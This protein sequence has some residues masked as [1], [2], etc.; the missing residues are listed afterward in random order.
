MER[1]SRPVGANLVFALRR[2]LKTRRKGEHEVRPYGAFIA[3]VLTAVSIA[4]GEDWPAWRGPAGSGVARD[5]RLPLHWGPK[6]NLRWRTPLPD[7]GNSTPIVCG[8]RVLLTQA[9]EKDNR[10]TVMC[11]DRRDGRVLWTSG[12]AAD[13]REPS[14]AQNPSCS[15]SPVTD[16]RVVVAYFGSPGLF[17]YDVSDGREL[18][19]RELGR[20]DS[21]QG[22]GSSPVIWRDLCVV[23]AGPGTDAAVVA[24]ELK[25]GREVW[26]IQSPRAEGGGARPADQPPPPESN[27]APDAP[28]GKFDDAMMAA[29]P[30]GAGGYLGSWST[31]VLIRNGDREE[32]VVVHPLQVS[33]YDPATGRELWTCREM[34]EQAFASPAVAGD[35]LVALGRPHDGGGTRATAIKLSGAAADVTKTHRLWQ[36][37]LTKECVGSPVIA[38][39]HVYLVT[40]F[41]S[42]ICLDLVT[43]RKLGEQR[44]AGEGSLGGSWSSLV[45]AG[46][47]LLVPNQSGEVF[48]FRATPELELLATNAAGD[49]ITCASLAVSDGD[50]FV[51]T[52]KALWCFGAGKEPGR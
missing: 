50:V 36:T 21:W 4:H 10:R 49:E 37:R 22:S 27:K 7:R 17:C 18:W 19:R 26:R 38:G 11:L 14:T 16:G 45:L 52:Y 42:L 25:S 29:D 6:Q 43:G 48:V 8:D 23:N 5:A 28:V 30:R 41:G 35:V 24:C 47:K 13:E 51:R 3:V 20:V 12:V 31:P 44:L 15:G 33:A 40:T 2:F 32:L 39:R 9:I 46:E 34:P 1:M